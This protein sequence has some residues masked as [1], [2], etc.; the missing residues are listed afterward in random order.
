MIVALLTKMN[1]YV[2]VPTQ[3]GVCF[4]PGKNNEVQRC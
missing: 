1:K 3:T 2:T 4:D